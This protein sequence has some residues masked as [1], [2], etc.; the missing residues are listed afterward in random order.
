ML[1]TDRWLPGS[2]IT[3]AVLTLGNAI[4]LLLP[5][6]PPSLWCLVVKEEEVKQREGGGEEQHPLT[7]TNSG[8]DRGSV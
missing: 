8:W 2:Y 6:P 4:F 1:M 5:P 7:R 3:Y